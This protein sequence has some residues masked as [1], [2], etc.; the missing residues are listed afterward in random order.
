[1]IA[2]ENLAFIEIL[3]EMT[4]FL[5]HICDLSLRVLCYTPISVPRYENH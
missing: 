3:K 1:M 4:I 5:T 2:L